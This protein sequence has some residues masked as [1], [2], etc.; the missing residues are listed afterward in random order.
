VAIARFETRIEDRKAH[1]QAR[2]PEDWTSETGALMPAGRDR[3]VTAI[4]ERRAA[5][6]DV[7]RCAQR[8]I[9]L[10]LFRCTDK[11]ILAELAGAT[12]RGVTVEAL[13]TARAKGGRQRL[14]KLCRELNA[15]GATVHTYNDPV[16]KYHAKY[17][18]ADD[19]PALVTS[20]NFTKKCLKSTVDAL[21]V[22][23]DPLVVDSLRQLFA[24]DRDGAALPQSLTDRLIIGPERARAQ[25]TA[26]IESARKRIR[27]IDA[28]LTDPDIWSRL[29]AKRA[30][31]VAVEI[32]SAKRLG[33]FKSHGKFVLVDDR[34]GAVGALA[35]S[36][37]SL[38]F[39]REVAIL[40]DD[41]DVLDGI[42]TLF[43]ELALWTPATESMTPFKVGEVSAD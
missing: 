38:D 25:L 39:R 26:L 34:I 24:A 16:V 35:L 40:V 33:P 37:L 30:A 15:T 19:G 32:Y 17:L 23:Y 3:I 9:V 43:D 1:A 28:K 21:V 6:L 22:T 27:I 36:A 42:S 7:I 18:V 5:I 8:H 20:L 4:A 41:P 13:V 10:S 2:P 11:A 14:E 12:D 31:G 29:S